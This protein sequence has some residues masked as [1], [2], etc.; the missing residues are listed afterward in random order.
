MKTS[1]IRHFRSILRRLERITNTQLRNCCAGVTLAQCLV[2]LEIDECGQLTM[3]RLATGLRLDN[4]TLSR[5]IDGLVRRGL[6]EYRDRSSTGSY[7]RVGDGD[8]YYVHR[9]TVLLTT[10]GTIAPGR[11]ADAPLARLIRFSVSRG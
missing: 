8:E 11:S 6:V 1:Q 10:S 4:S 7:I 3:S 5:T 9:Q 2:L